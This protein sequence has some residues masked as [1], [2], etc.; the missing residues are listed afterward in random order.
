MIKP[1]EKSSHSQAPSSR[2]AGGDAGGEAT[3]VQ[4]AGG[5]GP[6]AGQVRLRCCAERW[7]GLREGPS[8]LTLEA[9]GTRK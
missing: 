1:F 2:R 5:P 6:G 8:F 7:V 4:G 3:P 9:T